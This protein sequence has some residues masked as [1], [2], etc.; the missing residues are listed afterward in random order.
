VPAATAYVR[1]PAGVVTAAAGKADIATGERATAAHRTRAGSITKTFVATVV[2]QL[3][4]ERRL[5]LDTRL[6]AVCMTPACP[7]RTDIGAHLLQHTSGLFNFSDDP[8]LY[9]PFATDPGYVWS[10]DALIRL[11]AQ[12][13]PNFAPGTGWSY[14]NTNYVVLGRIVEQIT[15]NTLRESSPPA[16][17]TPLHLDGTYFPQR[18]TP[19]RGRHLHGYLPRTDGAPYD[20]TGWSTSWAWASGSLVS[21][22]RTSAAST[23]PCS[24][25]GC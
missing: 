20:V 23:A 2:L 14:S 6:S 13:A 4:E 24:R 17:W 5:T 12:H 7:T 21:T 15:G 9:E 3:V 25:A 18:A 10:P 16:S 8:R 1:T 11:A 19:L 22:R